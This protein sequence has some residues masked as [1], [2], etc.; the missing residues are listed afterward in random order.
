MVKITNLRNV[1][2]AVV[3]LTLSEALGQSLLR[4]FFETG[5]DMKYWYLPFM[6]WLLYGL[7]CAVLLWGYQYSDL[8]A[9]ET[10][11]DAGTSVVVPIVA[12]LFFKSTLN[13]KAGLGI[14]ITIIGI[15]LIGYGGLETAKQGTKS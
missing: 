11:W 1:S 8:S 6:T 12:I 2:I 3:I 13:L 10:I 15:L 4:K 14:L 9:I 7:C 5:Y